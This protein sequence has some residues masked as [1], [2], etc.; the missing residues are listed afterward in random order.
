[1]TDARLATVD[2]AETVARLLH[3]FNTEFDTESPG[4]ATLAP[5]LRTL[6]AGTATF[7]VLGGNGPDGVALVTL[8]TNVW[9]DGP[10]A[11]LDELYVAAALRGRGIGSEMIALVAGECAARGVELLEVNVDEGD[12]D[13][14]RFYG[15]HDFELVQ[16]ETGERAFYLSRTLGARSVDGL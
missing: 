3:D 12:V 1:M 5:R 15:R 7:A 10:V 8:R 6:L 16:P 4:P 2:D 14:L 11:L 13:A 9:F